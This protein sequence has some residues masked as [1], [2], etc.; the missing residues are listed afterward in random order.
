MTGNITAGVPPF[1]LPPFSTTVDGEYV[2]F[3]DMISTVGAS[4]ASIPMIAILEIVAISK[5][6][7]K[8]LPKYSNLPDSNFV[9]I[10]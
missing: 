9:I 10:T 5:A 8:Y 6:F 2:S 1:R 3:G 7:C 4:L